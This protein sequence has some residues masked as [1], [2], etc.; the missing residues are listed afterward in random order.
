MSSDGGINITG[1]TITGGSNII[2]KNE[3][4]Q[5]NHFGATAVGTGDLFDAI[6]KAIP[7]AE[8]DALIEEVIDPLEAKANLP[9]AEQTEEVKAEAETL[10]SRLTPYAPQITK[11]L[12]TLGEAGLTALATSNPIVSII[13][14][15]LRAAKT[16][17][18]E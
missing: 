15:S 6:E 2:G 9:P 16:M 10:I 17:M 3:G 4:G 18:N 5:H 13:V 1:V 8:V 11:T 7:E 14:A 12:V